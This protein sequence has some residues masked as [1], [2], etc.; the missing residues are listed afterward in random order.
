VE[1]H[2]EFLRLITLDRDFAQALRRDWRSLDLSAADRAM[3]EYTEMV[4]KDPREVQPETLDGLRAAGFD[5]TAILQIT[6]IASFFNYIN[7][8]ADALGVGR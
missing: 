6:M 1:S 8:M 7:R 3:L 2:A 4:T 5:D